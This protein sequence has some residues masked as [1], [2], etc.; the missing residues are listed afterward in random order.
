MPNFCWDEASADEDLD[1]YMRVKRHVHERLVA[2]RDARNPPEP[3]HE[4]DND[5]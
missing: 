5:K 3:P 4:E 2:L 1:T